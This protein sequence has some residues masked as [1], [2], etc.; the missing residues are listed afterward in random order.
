MTRPVDFEVV[1]ESALA[2]A[3]A[4]IQKAIKER[5]LS[6]SDLAKR[7]GRQRSFV[8]RM[9][10]GSHNL[11][12]KTFALALAAC[13]FEVTLGYSP[14]RWKW[15]VPEKPTACKSTVSTREGGHTRSCGIAAGAGMPTTLCVAK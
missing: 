10:S 4:T 9:M 11:T 13:D 1:Q 14:L 6:R 8:T 7:M 3:Q 12:I 5:N 2:M 15:S